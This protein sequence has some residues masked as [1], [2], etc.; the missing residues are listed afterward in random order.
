MAG[1]E[2]KKMKNKKKNKKQEQALEEEQRRKRRG[3]GRTG[4]DG[5]VS[6]R[7]VG[8]G[9]RVVYFELVVRVVCRAVAS[10]LWL[11]R[12]GWD[13]PFGGARACVRACVC[14]RVCVRVCV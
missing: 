14:V 2:A 3:G 12:L 10:P 7:L 1:V 4:D 9:C 11:A 5:V 8:C 13:H 6:E